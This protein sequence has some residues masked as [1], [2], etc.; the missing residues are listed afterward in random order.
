MNRSTIAIALIVDLFFTLKK[1]Q[2]TILKPLLTIL[3]VTMRFIVM[4]LEITISLVRKPNAI[5]E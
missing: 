3:A 5:V 2:K 1:E 4:N